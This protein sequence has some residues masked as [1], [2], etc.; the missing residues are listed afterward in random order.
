MTEKLPDEI[1][2]DNDTDNGTLITIR[3]EGASNVIAVTNLLPKGWRYA[4]AKVLVI[5]KDKL[6][7]EFERVR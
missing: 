4:I 1:I 2:G 7:I 5:D 3:K 6:T